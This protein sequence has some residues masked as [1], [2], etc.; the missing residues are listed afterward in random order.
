MRSRK[1][2]FE[3]F[4]LC[5]ESEIEVDDDFLRTSLLVLEMMKSESDFDFNKFYEDSGQVKSYYELSL[6]HI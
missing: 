4:W 5:V 2:D 1:A 6:I 3:E